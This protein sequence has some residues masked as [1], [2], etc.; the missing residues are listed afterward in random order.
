MVGSPG[1]VKR[2]HSRSRQGPR[3]DSTIAGIGISLVILLVGFCIQAEA[4]RAAKLIDM[5]LATSGFPDH[6]LLSNPVQ[7]SKSEKQR[8][9]ANVDEWL[10]RITY[11]LPIK[12]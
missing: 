3:I 11:S 8:D 2:R 12:M 1:T 10:E 4:A 5:T 7:N 6:S 9:N